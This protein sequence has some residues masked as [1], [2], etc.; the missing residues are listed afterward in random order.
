[1][2]LTNPALATFAIRHIIRPAFSLFSN[3]S[4]YICLIVANFVETF[5]TVLSI[6]TNVILTFAKPLLKMLLT[7]S[8]LATIAI[9]MLFKAY[10]STLTKGGGA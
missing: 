1:M 10:L 5:G 8:T 2:L 6:Y 4:K 9:W 7:K 3:V